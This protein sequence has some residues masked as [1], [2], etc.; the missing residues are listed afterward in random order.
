MKGEL[1]TRVEAFFADTEYLKQNNPQGFL[2][3]NEE[4]QRNIDDFMSKG[5][6]PGN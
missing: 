4:M 5:C 3:A 1:R 2:N 6:K